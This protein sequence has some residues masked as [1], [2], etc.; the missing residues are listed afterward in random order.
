MTSAPSRGSK[1][2][3]A[4]GSARG[5]SAVDDAD[6]AD[7]DAEA[8]VHALIESAPDGMIVHD[9]TTVAYVNAALVGALGYGDAREL[10]GAPTSEIFLRKNREMLRERM[11]AARETGKPNPPLELE[12][13]TKSGGTRWFEC[14]SRGLIYEGKQSFLVQARD[15]EERRALSAR[16]LQAEQLASLGTL[17]AG[18]AHEINNPLTYVLMNLELL[19]RRIRA[20]DAD[21][22]GFVAELDAASE[23]LGRVRDIVGDLR[24]FS[25]RGDGKKT[26]LDVRVVLDSAVRMSWAEIHHRAHLERDYE[27]VPPVLAG[28]SRL[29]QVFLNLLVNAAQSF[30]EG[31]GAAH[32]IRVTTRA[33]AGA[34]LV[35]VQDDGPGMSQ[36][37]LGRAFEPFFTTKPAGVGTGLGLSICHSIVTSLGGSIAIESALGRGT[38]FT[39]TLPAHTGRSDHAV[40]SAT[41]PLRATRFHGRVM[42]VDDERA[43]G[44]S[45]KR[46]LA[47][48][49]DADVAGSAAEAEALFGGNDRYDAIL[50]DVMM[51]DVTGIELFERVKRT[52]AVLAGRFVFMTGGA[53]TPAARAFF[54]AVPLP[55][56]EKPFSIEALLD[57][58]ARAREGSF[59]P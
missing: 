45:L 4:D 35:A 21:V 1:G 14:S 28:D 16:L 42:V 11:R 36:E 25:R 56:L 40:S 7:F 9:G 49:W 3:T 57:A 55:R 20:G 2:Q 38:T 43:I 33:H 37:A 34:V 19:R 47:G 51:P 58:L 23:G 32:T 59:S 27:A 18:V 8:R 5:V 26:P 30:P 48:V 52:D 54:E 44:E 15:V 22:A 46:A 29:S 12:L 6:R 17:A 53:F 10:V 31:D 13:M 24:A 50:C 39:V 41:S